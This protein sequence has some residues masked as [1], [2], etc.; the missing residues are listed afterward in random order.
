ML[1]RWPRVHP[2]DSSI[3]LRSSPGDPDFTDGLLSQFS[4]SRINDGDA[5]HR[6]FAHSDVTQRYVP[7]ASEPSAFRRVIRRSSPGPVTNS[8][9]SAIP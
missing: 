6:T 3:P 7:I 4:A 5:H 2:G 8:V 1:E 9:A